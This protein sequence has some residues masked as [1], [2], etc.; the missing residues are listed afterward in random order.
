MP[1]EVGI[2]REDLQEKVV[3]QIWQLKPYKLLSG[4]LPDQKMINC[5]LGEVDIE[6]K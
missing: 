4:D 3:G 5:F 1:R 2:I 6:I